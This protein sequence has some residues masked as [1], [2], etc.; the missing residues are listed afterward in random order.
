MVFNRESCAGCHTIR[1]TAAQGKIGPD[2]TAFGARR[3][4]GAM[5]VPNT[6]TNLS[7]WIRNSQSIKPGNL[8]PPV[9]LSAQDLKS[10]V[11][12]LESLK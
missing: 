5:T 7:R 12:Y 8:M 6:A 2:L 11:T 9:A 3:S 10:L 4:I 1:D